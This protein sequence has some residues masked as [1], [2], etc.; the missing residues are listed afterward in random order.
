MAKSKDLYVNTAYGTVTESAAGALTFSE[1]QTSVSIFEKVAWI[2]SR[3]EWYIPPATFALIIG[4]PDMWHM[5][6]T[7]SNNLTGLDLNAAAVIDLF[8]FGAGNVSAGQPFIRDWSNM[9]GGG[10]IVAPRPLYV[11]V[12]G[13]SMATPGSVQCRIN[14]TQK[15][16]AADEY[17]E[18]ID[19]YRIVQ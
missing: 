12:L 11:A 14:F 6:L 15:V 13:D 2:I 4:A 8:E 10:K 5:A 16:L 18:L 7:A 1:I 19:F 3:I 9:S 17:I